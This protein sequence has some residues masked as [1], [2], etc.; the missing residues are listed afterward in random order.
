[1]TLLPKPF[2]EF[3]EDDD[4]F[5][6]V[7]R[8]GMEP[9]ID[10]YE[11]DKNVVAEVSVPDMKAKDIKVSLEDDILRITGKREEKDE[12]KERGY[13]KKEIKKGSFERAVRLPERVDEGSADAVY[14]NGI[15]K[16]TLKK[17]EPGKKGKTKEI[18]V[19]EK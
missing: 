2:S 7:S 8:R 12:E 15:L 19:K 17:K 9:E 6:P 13:Y 18:K 4:W 11:T 16:V 10:V 1:M 14:E 5:F 3:I